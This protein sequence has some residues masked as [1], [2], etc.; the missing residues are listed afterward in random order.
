[1]TTAPA[2]IVA[3]V[4]TLMY[5]RICAPVPTKTPSPSVT[6]PDR[7]T[8]GLSTQPAPILA[9]CPTVHDRLSTANGSIVT[10]TVIMTPA[11]MT[12]PSPIVADSLWDTTDG[13]MSAGHGISGNCCLSS[14]PSFSRVDGFPIPSARAS[15]LFF[16][17]H[18]KSPSS[19]S[20]LSWSVN[21]ERSLTRY[22]I[23]SYVRVAPYMLSTSQATSR[24]KPP[25]PTTTIRFR[26]TLAPDDRAKHSDSLRLL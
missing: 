1:M 21:R 22:P 24:A 15:T 26:S 6:P 9:S 20:R 18:E 3:P 14:L 19:R 10:P 12:T 5:W 16:F 17:N 13:W 25:A 7:L 4:P 23:K 8:V 2:P 11:Q